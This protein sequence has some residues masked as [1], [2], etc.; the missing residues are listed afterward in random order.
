MSDY[1]IEA[2]E[3]RVDTHDVK[4]SGLEKQVAEFVG[5]VKVLGFILSATVVAQVILQLLHLSR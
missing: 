3:R 2:L 5:A 4:I 1:R